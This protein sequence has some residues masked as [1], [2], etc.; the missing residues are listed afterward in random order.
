VLKPKFATFAWATLVY[1]LA[2]ILL[3][4]VVQATGSGDGCGS[5]WPT[6]G[7]ALL[8]LDRGIATIIESSHRLTSEL[9]GL[10]A[11]VLVIWAWRAF[12]AGSRVRKAAAAAL[13]FTLIEGAIGAVLV[14]MGLVADNI[15][16]V[17]A[18]IAPLHLVNTL[19]LLASIALAAWWASK[20]QPLRLHGQGNVGWGLGLGLLGLL[21][22]TTSG[23]VTSL[24]DV[25][26]PIRNSA[27]AL[28]LSRTPGE[29]VLVYLRIYHPYIAMALSLYLLL[30][31]A[32]V[33]TA[34]PSPDTRQLSGLFSLFF[35]L[36]LGM[37]YLNI[38]SAAAL[39]TQ[40]PHLLLS[41]LVWLS[42]LLL[43]VAALGVG[44]HDLPL[45]RSQLTSH[46]SQ[47]NGA[48]P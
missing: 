39:S 48:Q 42:W 24:G 19:F 17:R 7:G 34:R 46:K 14:R 12:P 9:M 6:C 5:S 32:W 35:V 1:T 25:L 47:V 33:R 27:E 28:A 29:H 41:D 8:P 4:D 16:L 37:G 43:T 44:S 38:K 3:G 45:E 36:Q 23:A 26:F 40:L 10:L 11:V 22:L 2:V 15:T 18:A 13:V 20:P 31:A 30:V 21:L